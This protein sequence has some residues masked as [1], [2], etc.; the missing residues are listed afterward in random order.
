M[1]PFSLIRGAVLPFHQT[2]PMPFVIYILSE[3]NISADPGESTCS[4]FFIKFIIS[5]I[6]GPTIIFGLISFSPVTFSMFQT[7][8]ELS[9]ICCCIVPSVFTPSIRSA[10]FI[11]SGVSISITEDICSFTFFQEFNPVS[12]ILISVR[13]YM[14]AFPIGLSIY[15][16]SNVG[17]SIDPFPSTFTLFETFEPIS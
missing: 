14:S 13:P 3:V 5:L 2:F 8:L 16:V 12:F 7:I 6:L 17:V 15:P 10:F 4:P 1:G 9:N 11:L